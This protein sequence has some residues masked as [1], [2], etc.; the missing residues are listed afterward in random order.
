MKVRDLIARLSALHSGGLLDEWGDELVGTLER[1]ASR[2][3]GPT[4]RQ[5]IAAVAL[6]K[7]FDPAL[8]ARAVFSLRRESAIHFLKRPNIT[9]QQGLS[10]TKRRTTVPPVAGTFWD[11]RCATTQSLHAQN[12]LNKE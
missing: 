6:L 9:C 12:R 5:R 1:Q 8:T 4:E 10:C 2:G 3:Q 7:K 11:V